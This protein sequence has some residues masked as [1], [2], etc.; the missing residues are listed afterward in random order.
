MVGTEHM[1]FQAIDPEFGPVI[2]SV[3]DVITADGL[4]MTHMILRLSLG[5]FQQYIESEDFSEPDSLIASAKCLCPNL[6]ISSFLP[7]ISH[8]ASQMIAEYDKNSNIQ[9]NKFKFGIIY[10][11][12]G[13]IYEDQL[14]EN[15]GSSIKFEA[16]L[17]FL[18]KRIKLE[19][20]KGYAGGLDTKY[21][22]TGLEAIVETYLD[23]EIIFH[24]STLLPHSDNDKQQLARKRH[25]GNDIV[26]IVFQEKSTPFSPDMISSQFLH[27]YIVVQPTEENELKISVVTKADVEDFGPYFCHQGVYQQSQALKEQL[28]AKL[29]NAEQA[30]YKSSIFLALE[31]RTRHTMLS[32]VTDKLQVETEKFLNPPSRRGSSVDESS[33]GCKETGILNNMKSMLNKRT[34]SKSLLS[35][36]SPTFSPLTSKKR[37]KVSKVNNCTPPSTPSCTSN[38][39]FTYEPSKLIYERNSFSPTT[40]QPSWKPQ[41]VDKPPEKAHKQINT[42]IAPVSPNHQTMEYI[43]ELHADI[44]RLQAEKLKLLRTKLENH[45]EIVFLRNKQAELEKSLDAVRKETKLLRI[46]KPIMPL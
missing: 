23:Y 15:R 40:E 20:Y 22:Q 42:E 18:G 11:K 41:N 34:R 13:Q 38:R 8:R 43:I 3:K 24:V 39:K 9:G 12:E 19:G 45:R 4:K 31:R 7:I 2:A 44:E 21:N 30:C 17:N 28:L 1:N 35:P 25:I 5:T 33:A 10:Q 14:F 26:A 46:G 37:S 32:E 27:A 36:Q 16:F 29:I 6:T